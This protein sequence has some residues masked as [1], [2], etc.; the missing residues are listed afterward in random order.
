MPYQKLTKPAPSRKS[1]LRI[2]RI[3]YGAYGPCKWWPA[4]GPFEVILGAILTQNTTWSNV[5]KAIANLKKKKMID[6]VKLSKTPQ[7]KI[8]ELIKPA[9]YFR[10]KAKKIKT[11]VNYFGEQYDFS[12]DEMKAKP[13][14]KLREELIDVWGIGPETAD[15]I[16]LYAFE[17]PTF[18]VDNYTMR[19][20]RR[21]G[22]LNKKDDYDSTQKMFM[23]Y[24]AAEVPLFN[25][26]H[27]CIVA[28]GSN[29]CGAKPTCED[30]P[31]K[32]KIYCNPDAA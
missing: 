31:L 3:L 20:F 1:L 26:Y 14:A 12:I 30:C 6:P 7:T 28:F 9:G 32:G 18:V 21:L 13:L 24:L 25:E 27:A 17:K 10:Q 29:L 16:L 15:S 23:K 11:F 5:E 19:I 4:D 8:A 2:Y 22:Y